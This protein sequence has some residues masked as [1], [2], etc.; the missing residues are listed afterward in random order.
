MIPKASPV[1]AEERYPDGKVRATWS[2]VT[3]VDGRYLLHGPESWFYADGSKQY[4]VNYAAGVKTGPERYWARGGH[5]VWSWQHDPDG[6]SAWTRY[7]PQ[8]TRKTHSVWRQGRCIGTATQWDPH[9]KV[10]GE[11][12][13]K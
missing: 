10:I 4:E 9:G 3:T 13:F 1:R 8:G 12:T 11:W 2:A 7:W 5:L 6:S